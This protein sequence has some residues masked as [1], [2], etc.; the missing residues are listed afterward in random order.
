MA[1]GDVTGDG[2]T[3]AA[4]AGVGV[5]R[6]IQAEKGLEYL[7]APVGGNAGTVIINQYFNRRTCKAADHP[8]AAAMTAG[9]GQQIGDAALQPPACAAAL[10]N[11]A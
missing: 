5:A 9:I 2:Q 10:Q 6:G 4:A 7:F 3:K 1:A 11:P 8:G